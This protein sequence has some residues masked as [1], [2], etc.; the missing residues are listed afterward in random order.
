MDLGRLISL[1]MNGQQPPNIEDEDGWLRA[2]IP[3]GGMWNDTD[4][5]PTLYDRMIMQN[6]RL[7]QHYSKQDMETQNAPRAETGS[8]LNRLLM[9]Y[10]LFNHMNSLRKK[11]SL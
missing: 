2:Q 5:I 1:L 10:M 6:P 4:H 9:Q 11:S 7:M 8:D 3:N